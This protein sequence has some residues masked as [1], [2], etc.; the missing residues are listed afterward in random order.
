MKIVVKTL[1][2][3]SL[4]PPKKLEFVSVSVDDV[5]VIEVVAGVGVPV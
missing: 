2:F 4:F 5:D 1:L 3:G